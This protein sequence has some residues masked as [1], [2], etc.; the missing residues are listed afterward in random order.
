MTIQAKSRLK[1]WG[2]SLGVT[3]PRE[4]V[5]KEDL[6]PNDEVTISIAKGDN[7]SKLFGKGKGLKI[8]PQK[9]KDESRKIWDL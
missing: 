2:N 3:I 1:V 9:M 6:E 4:I 7:L 8:D 5:I